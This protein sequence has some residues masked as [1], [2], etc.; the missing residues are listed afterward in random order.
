VQQKDPE[1][2]K[3]LD[4][5]HAEDFQPFQRLDVD[6]RAFDEKTAK[7]ARPKTAAEA[8]KLVDCDDPVEIAAGFQRQ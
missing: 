6:R 5:K 3:E 8:K 7:V 1:A 2:F 4:Y